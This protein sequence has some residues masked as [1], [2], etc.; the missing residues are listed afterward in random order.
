M[1]LFE[2]TCRLKPN[3]TL[4]V[5][6]S[7]L[8]GL[9]LIACGSPKSE[10]HAEAYEK[11]SVRKS[12]DVDRE[13]ASE[14][15]IEEEVAVDTVQS[16]IDELDPPGSGVVNLDT[17]PPVRTPSNQA[18]LN[19]VAVVHEK[20]IRQGSSISVHATLG[21]IENSAMVLESAIADAETTD[22]SITSD[23]MEI[24]EDS[25]SVIDSVELDLIDPLEEFKIEL[26]SGYKKQAYNLNE[27]LS[28]R[29][30]VTA[31]SELA[32][33]VEKRL[34]L[35]LVTKNDRGYAVSKYIN[36]KVKASLGYWD[37]LKNELRDT[38]WLVGIIGS[39][40]AFLVGLYFKLKSKAKASN[41]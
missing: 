15:Y 32:P 2:I 6:A 28:W 35:I 11:D 4:Y 22:G 1:K 20:E 36:L 30:N 8:F 5:A 38:K 37:H 21:R 27:V 16:G 9:T 14:G 19:R 25:F 34:K 7:L 40:I 3:W 13:P 10:E 23:E 39:A 41:E 12:N 33:G 31:N 24:I 17:V 18:I 29:W 26:I